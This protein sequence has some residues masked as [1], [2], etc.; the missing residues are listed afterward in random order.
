MVEGLNLLESLT[1]TAA[2]ADEEISE[3]LALAV[4]AEDESE[5]VIE[6]ESVEDAVKLVASSLVEDAC[7]DEDVELEAVEAAS[8]EVGVAEALEDDALES[9]RET[10]TIDEEMTVKAGG[11]SER[12]DAV[13]LSRSTGHQHGPRSYYPPSKV[14]CLSP[15]ALLLERDGW[16]CLTS[17][18]ETTRRRPRKR[19][20][21]GRGRLRRMI[22]CCRSVLDGHRGCVVCVHGQ[23]DYNRGMRVD[24]PTRRVQRLTGRAPPAAVDPDAS[25][26]LLVA[27][28]ASGMKGEKRVSAVGQGRFRVLKGW[29]ARWLRRVWV[30]ANECLAVGASRGGR[31]VLEW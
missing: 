8:E 21:V 4:E 22:G 30:A 9:V 12:T 2:A 18:A 19:R 13:S 23:R 14:S 3:E 16:E 29:L 31:G 20:T 28:G 7:T 24:Q 11:V 5:E 27:P 26:V 25:E 1:T 6:L 10:K 15:C 17:C